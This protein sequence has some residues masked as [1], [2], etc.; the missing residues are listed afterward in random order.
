MSNNKTNTELS[1]MFKAL[2][3]PHRLAIFEKLFTCCKPGTA[4]RLESATSL[5]VGDLGESLNIAPSTV[6]HHIKELNRAGLVAMERDGKKI[7]CRINPES[8]EQ[9][10]RYFSHS[11][12]DPA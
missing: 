11:T 12:G 2:S 4:C 7:Y 9:L 1:A 10:A 6:S 8:I 3:N 5:C